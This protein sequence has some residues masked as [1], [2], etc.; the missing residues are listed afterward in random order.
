MTRRH[1]A[2]IALLLSPLAAFAQ[3]AEG[4]SAEQLRQGLLLFKQERFQEASQ[5]FRAVVQE[6][7]A[8]SARPEAYYWAARSYAAMDQ[9]AEAEQYLE[10]FLANYSWHPLYAD[11]LY[12]KGRILYLQGEAEQAIQV[13][14]EYVNGYPQAELVSSGYF[15]IAESLYSLGH[16]DEAAQI[17]GQIVDRYP[18]SVKL[19]AARYRLSLIEFKQRE[20]ELLRLLQWSHLEAIK[21]ADE[22]QRRERTYEQALAARQGQPGAA[23]ALPP[24]DP[25]QIQILQRDKAALEARIRELEAGLAAAEAGAATRADTPDADALAAREAL[26]QIKSEALGLKQALLDRLAEQMR[27]SE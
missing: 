1:I 22:Y 12:Q 19:E 14:G 3:G 13:L 8:A 10:H 9:L 6:P 24:A 15:W 11:G 7:Q 5:A 2:L 25:A 27:K 21:A 4:S 17:Y 26:L 23:L 20:E 18:K 16:I